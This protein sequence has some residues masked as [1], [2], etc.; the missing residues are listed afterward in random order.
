MTFPIEFR[1]R[2]D[3]P[4]DFG[5]P[6]RPNVRP[7]GENFGYFDLKR[8]PQRIDDIPELRDWPPL[9]KM[10]QTLNVP[11]SFFRTVGCDTGILD[12]SG[13]PPSK[14]VGCYFRIAFELLKWNLEKDNYLHLFDAI[15][16]RCVSTQLLN[17]VVVA[18]GIKPTHFNHH[19]VFGWTLMIDV[20]GYAPTEQEARE[21]WTQGMALIE[22]S[23]IEISADK[24]GQ[25]S[26]GETTIS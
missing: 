2:E 1:W 5:I 3:P 16:Q 12:V 24:V 13:S 20:S 21:S 4:E 8:D 9:R 26:L 18:G 7:D 23:F 17:R 19:Q 14:R 6:Y 11:A 22:N 10:V 25:L 15:Y